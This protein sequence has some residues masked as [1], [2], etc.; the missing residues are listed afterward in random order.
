M[1]I[2]KIFEFRNKNFNEFTTY[3][4]IFFDKYVTNWNKF[5]VENGFNFLKSEILV[6][7][8]EVDKLLEKS[9]NFFINQ[10][11]NPN[12]TFIP[13]SVFSVNNG[14]RSD[15]V[16]FHSNKMD[17][18]YLRSH[19]QY[20]S[21]FMLYTDK[22]ARI[23]DFYILDF[24]VPFL[25]IAVE[26]DG[27]HHYSSNLKYDLT[28][29]YL[30]SAQEQ[31]TTIRISNKKVIELSYDDYKNIFDVFYS[32]IKYLTL[33]TVNLHPNFSKSSRT[34]LKEKLRD[35]KQSAALI[36]DYSKSLILKGLR[37]L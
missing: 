16:K 22:N 26:I 19:I 6:Q 34:K 12:Y 21:T 33:K 27:M 11:K 3:E 28:R 29:N 35:A 1:S 31:I 7:D 10:L 30:L 36:P 24:Y 25:K 13:Q 32:K 15:I 14:F 20:Y 23:P 4:R 37:D 17:L 2:K 5:F 18:K 8:E 9:F